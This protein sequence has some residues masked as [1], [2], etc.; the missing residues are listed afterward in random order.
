M[1]RNSAAGEPEDLPIKKLSGLSGERQNDTSSPT[2]LH[3]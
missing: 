2:L 1:G 3:K